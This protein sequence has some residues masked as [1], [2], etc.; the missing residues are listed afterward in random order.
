MRKKKLIT[1]KPIKGILF[2]IAFVVVMLM[3]V[4]H[5]SNEIEKIEI[6]NKIDTCGKY[7]CKIDLYKENNY[8]L[9]KILVAQNDYIICKNENRE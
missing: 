8:K 4:S 5:G 2:C 7:L 6:C 1:M 9:E 3:L